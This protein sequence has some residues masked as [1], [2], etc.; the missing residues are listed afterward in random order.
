MR[1]RFIPVLV[2]AALA[3]CT[4][5]A[6]GVPSGGGPTGT[7]AAVP[8]AVEV[9]DFML[10]PSALVATGPSVTIEVTNAG[11]TPHN[12]SVRDADGN[13]V[14]ATADL[15]TGDAETLRFEVEPGEYTT[16]CGLP[17]HESLGMQG[18]LVVEAG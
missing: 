14:A 8:L 11:P 17:G 5:A 18:T 6:T 1:T 15:S 9:S 3:A 12:F 4:P 13:L 16:F 10:D 2:F 7:A